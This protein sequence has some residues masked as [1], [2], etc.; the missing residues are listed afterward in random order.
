MLAVDSAAI[1][2]IGYEKASGL[3]RIRFAGGHEYDFCGVPAD[4]FEDFYN[5]PS[6]GEYYNRRVKG[7]YGCGY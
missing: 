3:L 5:A 7:R 6:K 2:A 1:E 4:V